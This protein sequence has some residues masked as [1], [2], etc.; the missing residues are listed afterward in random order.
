MISGIVLPGTGAEVFVAEEDNPLGLLG[1]A[2]SPPT[3]AAAVSLIVDSAF[4]VVATTATVS[5]G[6]E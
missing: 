2:S 4:F 1:A 5:D 6:S 3:G